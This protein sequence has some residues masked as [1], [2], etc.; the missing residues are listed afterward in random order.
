MQ[1]ITDSQYYE[2]P[3]HREDELSIF[4]GGKELHITKGFEFGPYTTDFYGIQYCIRGGF[5]IYTNKSVVEIK[6]GTLFVV[7]PYT[8]MKKLFTEEST[9]TYYIHVKGAD[10][11]NY[12]SALGFSKDDLVFP[13][14]VPQNSVELMRQ[15]IELLSTHIEMTIPEID[16]PIIPKTIVFEGSSNAATRRMKRR[17]LFQLF[18][19][20]LMEVCDNKNESEKKLRTKEEYIKKATRFIERNYNFDI[21]VDEV[22]KHVGLNRS[23]LYELFSEVLGMS[24]Q[25]FIISIR[26]RMACSLLRDPDLSIKS[27]AATVRYDPISFSRVFKKNFGISPTEYREKNGEKQR[28]K[29]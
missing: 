8:R 11:E 4:F 12:M 5:T 1:F 27:I 19:A 28:A 7:P 20:S 23:Y 9:A 16:A 18:L 29:L 10:V 2:K 3:D 24:V 25:E 21:N 14:K 22:A 26:L 15:I 6:E 13:H 17:G